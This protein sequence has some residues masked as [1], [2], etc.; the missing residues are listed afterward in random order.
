MLSSPINPTVT[1]AAL[2]RIS[3][4]GQSVRNITQ[5]AGDTEPHPRHYLAPG[6]SVDQPEGDPGAGDDDDQ[7]EVGPEKRYIQTQETNRNTSQTQH[8]QTIFLFLCVLG[9]IFLMK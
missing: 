7:R 4:A 5:A 8:Y 6:G 9:Y 1:T 2:Q 3:L